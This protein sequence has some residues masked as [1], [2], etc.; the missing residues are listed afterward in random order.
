ML[1]LVPLVIQN[2]VAVGAQPSASMS[3]FW[4][5]YQHPVR[6]AC[7]SPSRMKDTASEYLVVY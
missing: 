5:A 3:S 4:I 2:S 6:Q 7:E 1:F